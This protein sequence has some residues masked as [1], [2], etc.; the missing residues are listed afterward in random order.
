MSG[1]VV[2][3][4]SLRAVKGARG[5]A[6]AARARVVHVQRACGARAARDVVQRAMW[7]AVWCSTR[8]G[9]ARARVL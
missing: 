9:A 5:A 3:Q 4:Q 1:A 8:C 2:I 7:T 6:R